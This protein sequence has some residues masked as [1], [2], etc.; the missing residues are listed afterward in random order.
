MSRAAL[1][2]APDALYLTDDE[3]W[4]RISPHLTRVAFTKLVLELET[5]GFPRKDA[6]FGGRYYPAVRAWLDRRAG[7]GKD[8]P[9]VVDGQETWGDGEKEQIPGAHSPAARGLD[10]A[11]LERGERIDQGREISRALDPFTTRRNRGRVAGSL[12]DL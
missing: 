1:R 5:R 10:G 2:E 8:I 11:L 12:R 6:L 7:I 3:L 4:Q 9:A